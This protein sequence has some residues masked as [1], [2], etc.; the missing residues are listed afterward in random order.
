MW[1]KEAHQEIIAD[2]KKVVGNLKAV[3]G[4]NF[5]I[6]VHTPGRKKTEKELDDQ[7]ELLKVVR[8][9]CD[10][11]DVVPNLHNHTYEVENGLH[12]LKGTLQRLPDFKLGPDIGWL[13]KAGVDP[14]QF[15]KQYGKQ[16]VYMHLR[17][18]DKNGEWTEIPGHGVIDFKG[19]ADA[20]KETRFS[21]E[22]AIELAFPSNFKPSRPL[23]DSWKLSQ[24][25]I[26][27]IFGA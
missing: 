7:A 24:E 11:Q 13:A 4:R 25:Y 5:G 20:L 22:M 3:G 21:G 6:S 10:E 19:V 17:D 27:R 23:K 1:R 8:E 26:A 15:V 16:M 18:L 12:D 9:V 2:V 14:V